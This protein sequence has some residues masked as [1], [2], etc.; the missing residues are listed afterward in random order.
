MSYLSNFPPCFRTAAK[1]DETLVGGG[2]SS[3]RVDSSG[4]WLDESHLS[5]PSLVQRCLAGGGSAGRQKKSGEASWIHQELTNLISSYA[6]YT[7]VVPKAGMSFAV[8]RKDWHRTGYIFQHTTIFSPDYHRRQF[9]TTI[10]PNPFFS[11]R[12]TIVLTTDVG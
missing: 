10:D 3:N 1:I 11:V 4:C 6:V 7:S 12:M 8:Q 9:R 5:A 2:G